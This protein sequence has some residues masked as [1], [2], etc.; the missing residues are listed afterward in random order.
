MYKL[1]SGGPGDL[2][3]V[4]GQGVGGTYRRGFTISWSILRAFCSNVLSTIVRAIANDMPVT[5]TMSRANIS[6]LPILTDCLSV[7]AS[8]SNRIAVSSMVCICHLLETK[9]GIPMF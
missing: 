7:A 1:I 6:R 3:E 5:L 2:S 9:D 4:A 8:L